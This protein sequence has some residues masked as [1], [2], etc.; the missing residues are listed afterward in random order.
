MR[1]SYA[2]ITQIFATTA[3]TVNPND[4]LNQQQMQILRAPIPDCNDDPAL[5]YR[6]VINWF[7]VFNSLFFGGGL[8]TLR[9]HVRVERGIYCE[10]GDPRT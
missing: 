7:D 9:D 6:L 2:Q 10:R 3:P 8:R 1:F 4:K 5:V